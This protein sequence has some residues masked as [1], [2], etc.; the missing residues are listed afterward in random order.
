MVEERRKKLRRSTLPLSPLNEVET[1]IEEFRSALNRGE[2]DP[3][4]YELVEAVDARV[5]DRLNY[6]AQ[7]PDAFVAAFLRRVRSLRKGPPVLEENA[8][9]TILGAKYDGV[10]VRYLEKFE[11][12]IRVEVVYNKDP[13]NQPVIGNTYRIPESAID[14]KVNEF[15]EK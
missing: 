11:G 10:V 3:Y 13:K 1:F 5:A 6:S 14:R 8:C 15:G 4:L 7:E 12:K 2:F 9:Y